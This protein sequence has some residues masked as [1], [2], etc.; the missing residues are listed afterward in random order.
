MSIIT[1]NHY[2]A[3]IVGAGIAGL[4]SAAYLSKDG[5]RVLVIE[6]E[7]RN[8][9]LIGAFTIDGHIVDLGARGI[10]DSG[11]FTPMIKQL[12]LDI[13]LLPNPVRVAVDKH[14]VDFKDKS[15]I[16]DYG[17]MLT[18]LYPS[19][20]K[21][22]D[23]IIVEI[24][25]VM[26]YMYVLYGIENPLFMPKPYDN[27]Y[28]LTTLL[29][30]MMKFLINIRQAMKL[31]DPINDHLGKITDNESLINIITQHF[32]VSTPTFFALSYFSL[33]LDYLYPKGS[34]QAIVDKMVGLIE[35]QRGHIINGQEVILIDAPRRQ[36]SDRE[37]NHYA[38]DQLI[39]AAD[40]NA[41]YR[42]LNAAVWPNSLLKDEVLQKQEFLSSKK[43]ADS[44][45]SLY[46]IVDQPPAEFQ[47]ITGPHTFY[48]PSPEG[49]SGIALSDLIDDQTSF[50]DDPDRI[51]SWLATFVAQNTL[52]ISIPALRDPSLSPPG[53]CALIVSLLFDYQLTKHIADLGIYESF[54]MKITEL[55][56]K[57]LDNYLPELSRH[58]MKTVITTPLTIAARSNNTEGSLT[59]WSF[60]N[61]PFPAE[62]RF[63]KVS[64]SVLTPINTIKQAGQWTFNPAGVPVSI[65]T[66]KLAADAVIKDLKRRQLKGA[67][68]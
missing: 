47:A 40:L 57:T 48:T 54:K 2:D 10:I 67:D 64:Q 18:Q 11:I 17:A 63:L 13:E 42:C 61:S 35:K 58:V 53:E 33:Y 45:L 43:G 30:W 27:R 28:L 19:H 25:T 15:S 59:G 46:I 52:E 68:Q 66:G 49:L 37:G 6:K 22:I 36:V 1:N 56:M 14:S 5:Y 16:G 32:F 12:G 23:R 55:I 8:G 9:G 4:T 31:L 7:H 39:W 21:E 24:E 3:I 65:L 20:E 34:T 26:R 38:Y 41:L 29:P 60:T 51:F 44:V 50:T 62:Y